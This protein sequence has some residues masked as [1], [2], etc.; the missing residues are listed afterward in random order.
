MDRN[1]STLFVLWLSHFSSLLG[2]LVFVAAQS[3]HSSELQVTNQNQS[4]K[5][6]M[7]SRSGCVSVIVNVVS[8]KKR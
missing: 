1:H 8:E 7:P 4:R 3:R 6:D 2:V 5:H